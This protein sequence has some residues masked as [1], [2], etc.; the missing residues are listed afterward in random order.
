MTALTGINNN[1]TAGFSG[2]EISRCN[3]QANIL[4]T[5]NNNQ[6]GVLQ[7]L[8][9]VAMSLQQCLNHFAIGTCVA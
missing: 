6:T 9:T 2:A 8:N 3:S 4:Q 7:G 5:L 1:V